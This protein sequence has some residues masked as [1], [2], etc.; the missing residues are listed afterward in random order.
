MEGLSLSGQAQRLKRT[1]NIDQ[2]QIGVLQKEFK[3]LRNKGGVGVG[4]EEGK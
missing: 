1:A 3:A 2:V 4:R